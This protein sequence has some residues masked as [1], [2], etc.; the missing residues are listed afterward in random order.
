MPIDPYRPGSKKRLHGT[1]AEKHC[2]KRLGATLTPASGALPGAKG[3]MFTDRF[4]IESKATVKDSY[5]LSLDVLCK[6]ADEAS[7]Q[8]QVPAVAVQFVLP[9]GRLRR[10]GGWVCMPENVFKE[11]LE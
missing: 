11:L 9:D 6:A 2:A 1:E 10:C 5:R 3:D 7:E 8:G 4:R